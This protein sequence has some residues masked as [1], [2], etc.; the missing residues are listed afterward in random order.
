M[1][2][3]SVIFIFSILIPLCSYSQS[4]QNDTAKTVVK[5][6]TI[7]VSDEIKEPP[8]PSFKSKFNSLTEWLTAVAKGNRPQKPVSQYNIGL[9]EAPGSY[10]LSLNGINTYNDGADRYST[11]IDYTPRAMY[12]DLRKSYFRN[13]SRDQLLAKIVAELKSFTLTTAFKNSFLAKGGSIVFEVN[14]EVIWARK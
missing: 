14:G 13:L 8:P 6:Y 11:R 12:C 1:M 9:F 7:I 5:H 4:K 2:L 3:R 10:T